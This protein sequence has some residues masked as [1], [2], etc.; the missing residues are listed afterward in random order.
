MNPKL[1]FPLF[2]VVLLLFSG[3]G[4]QP[5]TKKLNR[6]IIG[7]ELEF[8]REAAKFDLW[9]E[10]IFRW[11]KV[12]KEDST[13]ADA[14][15]NLAVAYESVG[16]YQKAGDLYRNALDL[17]ED[18]REIRSNYK[19]F[20]SFYKRHQRQIEREKRNRENASDVDS[21][22]QEDKDSQD[23]NK[24]PQKEGRQ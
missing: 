8:G 7:E 17:D 14:M 2:S 15:N 6:K 9:H 18:S 10:A 20:Q 19:R 21:K 16:D 22:N 5:K 1:L 4:N 12:V 3:C 13:N 11:E 24:D 23:E